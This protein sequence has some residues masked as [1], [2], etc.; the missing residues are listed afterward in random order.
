[1]KLITKKG[2]E[3][4]ISEG[5]KKMG[6][7]PSFSLLPIVTCNPE[8]CKACGKKCYAVKLQRIYKGVS[9]SWQNN[10]EAAKNDLEGLKEALNGYF[11]R[12]NAP[13][14][15]RLHVSGDFFSR[16]YFQMW[17]EVITAHPETKFLAFTKHFDNVSID[18]LPE[19]FSLIASGWKGFN[20]P[21]TVAGLPV[22]F[23]R[24]KGEPE[25]ENLIECGGNC[26]A[27]GMCWAAKKII[28]ESNG[29]IRGFYFN[30]H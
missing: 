12:A 13:R 14:L 26:E 16:E 21:E 27:C 30:E 24:L 4:T 18:G 15:F 8:A 22:A 2:Y 1:M 3:I 23:C 10:T 7:I 9:T 17:A 19:N 5:N 28:S 25:P 20:I 6:G 29:K 11:N